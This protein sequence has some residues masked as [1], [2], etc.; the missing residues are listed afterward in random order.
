M[1]LLLTSSGISNATI[2]A[3]LVDLLGKPIAEASALFVP[4][5]IYPFPGGAHSAFAAISGNAPSRLAELGW[6]SLGVLEL[7]ALPSI[8]REVWVAAVQE[9]DALLVWGGDPVYLAYWMKHSGLAELLPSLRSEAVY[10]GVS[11]GSIAMA[12]TFGEVYTNP[13]KASGERLSTEELVFAGPSGEMKLPLVMA[14]GAGFVDFAI[15]PH[16]EFDDPN[17]LANAELWATRQAVPTYA[18]DD[19]TAIKVV[20]GI[21]EVV[22]EG[23]WCG[24]RLKTRPV[25]PIEN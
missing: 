2:N 22:S 21:T 11:A 8:E 15:I 6:K 3:A 23:D 13:P 12:T 25:A 5:A 1:K 17:D 7:T 19:A 4:T 24:R 10:V 9:T 14:H 16:V 18:I 20:D